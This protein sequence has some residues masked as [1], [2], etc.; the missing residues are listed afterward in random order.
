M[1]NV[2]P[3]EALREEYKGE[4]EA[5][6][7]PKI[8][9]GFSGRFHVLI[10][11]TEGLGIPARDKR[12]RLSHIAKITG[13]SK[14]AVSEWFKKNK[15]PSEEVFC[16]L[17]RFFLHH[18]SV[19]VSALR[20]E[21][22]LRYGDEATPNP[23]DIAPQEE[24]TEALRPV[25]FRLLTETVKEHQIGISTYDMQAV[26]DDT[27]ELLGDFG[28]GPSDDIPQPMKDLVAGFIAKHAK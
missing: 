10:D 6:E 4:Q 24:K 28:V 27:L 15:L 16:S 26:L 11:Q 20:V 8:R 18:T 1:S 25:A 23:F 7:N 12:G 17:I 21:S 5:T 22:W 14:P 19:K 3:F 2:V 13:H 9:P